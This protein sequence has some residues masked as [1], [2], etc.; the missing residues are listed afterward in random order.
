MAAAAPGGGTYITLASAPVASLA[1]TKK[2]LLYWKSLALYL[3][4]YRKKIPEKNIVFQAK[5]FVV[6][7]NFIYMFA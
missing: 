3:I 7:D 2:S 5:I 6:H 4:L 1:Y